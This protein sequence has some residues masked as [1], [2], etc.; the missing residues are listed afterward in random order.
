MS[1]YSLRQTELLTKTK[2]SIS[3]EETSVNASLLMRGGFVEKLMAGVYSFLPL[4]QR[5]LLNIENIVREEMMKI[6]AQEILMPSLQPKELWETTDR[7]ETMDILYKL[8]SSEN[9][10]L[11]L[12]PT[13]EEVVTPLVGSFIQSHKDLPRHVFQIQTKFRNEKRA[14]S[15]LLRGRE[16]R[17]KD[18][19]SFHTDSQ[20]LD[21]FYEKA[22][23]AYANIFKRCGLAEKTY[24]T[25]AS[26][27]AFSQYSHEYQTLAEYGEDYIYIWQEKN[28]AV[29]REIIEEVRQQ[30]EWKTAQF[31]ERK[32]IEVANIFKLGTRFSDAFN[33]AYQDASG[34]RC[35]VYMGCYG[36]GTTRLVGAIA[37]V[38]HDARGLL[39]PH[40]VS[41][42]DIHLVSLLNDSED[43]SQAENIYKCLSDQ[44]YKVLYD[45]RQLSAGEKFS[46]ADLIGIPVRVLIS[47][48]TLKNQSLEIKPRNSEQALLVE[49]ESFLSNPSDYL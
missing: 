11:L 2:R 17:M 4:G 41:P 40:E 47:V 25:Y 45:D 24:L 6:G 36:I 3:H 15:G 33:V 1:I 26:G 42:F 30:P 28:I 5:V 14:K 37:E 43:R 8:K 39:W 21:I 34:N 9:R 23:E 13:H 19:Y 29:N 22:K 48:K 46:D 44:G 16:F 12:G 18:M 32:S 35:P 49:I 27:G 20:D 7:W 10:D 31:E 38:C